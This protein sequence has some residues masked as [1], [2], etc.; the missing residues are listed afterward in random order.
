MSLG[1][2]KSSCSHWLQWAGASEQPFWADFEKRY[3]LGMFW[4]GLGMFCLSTAALTLSV[5]VVSVSF[6]KKNCELTPAFLVSFWHYVYFAGD[7]FAIIQQ[8]ILMM[9]DCKHPNIVGYFDSYLRYVGELGY[10][11]S[12]LYCVLGMIVDYS[13]EVDDCNPDCSCLW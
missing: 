13:S 7:D 12:D 6:I 2:W 11:W 1:C 5:P 3:G 4:L 9:K 10:G 8:E